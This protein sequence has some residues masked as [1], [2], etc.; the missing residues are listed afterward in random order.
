MRGVRE[1]HAATR[2]DRP[3]IPCASRLKMALRCKRG[4]LRAASPD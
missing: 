1:R 3:T 4:P 2:Y